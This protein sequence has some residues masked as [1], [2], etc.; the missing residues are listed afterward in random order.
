MALPASGPISGS[1]IGTELGISTGPYSLRNMSASASF[2]SPDAMSEFY[3]YSGSDVDF[4]LDL[5]AANASSYGGSGTTWTDLSGKG[6]NGTLTNRSA[7]N[8]VWNSSGW[9]EFAGSNA[10]GTYQNGRYV[11][12][13]DGAFARVQSQN[14]V[15][16]SVWCYPTENSYPM[17]LAGNS[18]N[19]GTPA[20]Q[21][22]QIFLYGGSLYGRITVNNGTTYTDISTAASFNTWQHC[23]LTYDGTNARFYKDDTLIGTN[24]ISGTINNI[25]PNRFLIGCQY[26]AQGATNTAEFYTGY[27]SKV[28][29]YSRVLSGPQRTAIYNA[30]R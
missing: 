10:Y 24:A 3:G 4:L 14:R 2:S 13:V 27:I 22:Y 7:A 28:R 29:L 23:F 19:G 21:G 1:Q 9:F 25:S 11:S 20:Y 8:P 26:N 6:N 18:Y 12:T 16:L 5:D 17:I 30:G 15:S